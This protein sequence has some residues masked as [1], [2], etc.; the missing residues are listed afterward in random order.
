VPPSKQYILSPSSVLYIGCVGRDKYADILASACRDAGL[1]T[2]YRVDDSQ[3]TGRCGVIITGHD[4]SMCTH[5]AAAN[6]YKLEHLQSPHVWAAVQKARVYY[7]GGYH[8]TVCV[9]AVMALAEEAARE[10]KVRFL[11]F[12]YP[13]HFHLPFPFP[14]SVCADSGSIM[15]CK[16]EEEAQTPTNPRL[17]S[18]IFILSLSAPFI[19]QFFTA[20]LDGTSPYWDYL[21][22]NE[23]EA[24]AYAAAHNLDTDDIPTIAK[25]L[26]R[27]PKKKAK[28]ARTVVVTQGTDPTVVA[29]ANPGQ[30]HGAKEED[31]RVEVKTFPVRKVGGEEICDTNG[32]G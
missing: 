25:H 3:P 24:R 29:V 2:E 28:R 19:P 27:L 31:V 11:F 20:P 15:C 32:A 5:L 16:A 12:F 10:D 6:E 9:P 22:G 18:Q 14:V 30:G 21:I 1:R 17:V 8:L 23:T 4:R 26:A 13:F 7:V